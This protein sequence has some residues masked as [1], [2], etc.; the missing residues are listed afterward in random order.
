MRRSHVLT[1]IALVSARCSCGWTYFNHEL[2]GK[3]D[4][5][6]VAETYSEFESHKLSM[7]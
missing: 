5:D 4:E 6:L 3:T 2:K 7:K 1:Q